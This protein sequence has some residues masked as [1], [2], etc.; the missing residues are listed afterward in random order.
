MQAA[1]INLIL[2]PGMDGTGDLF[3]PFIAALNEKTSSVKINIIT[4]SYPLNE[5]LSYPQLIKLASTH[6]PLDQPYI[7][8]GESF[9]GPV[10]IALASQGGNQLKG[11]ILCCTFARNPR[12]QLSRVSFML[13]TLPMNA[14]TMPIANRFLMANF[15]N[16]GVKKMLFSAQQKVSPRVM[17]AR[18]GAVIG[19]DYTEKLNSVK[20][21][22][23]YLQAINDYLVPP[24]A[25]KYIV[26]QAN[27][28][29]LVEL[30]APHML[31]QIAPSE[32]AE[33]V[34]TFMA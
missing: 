26:A 25:A 18:L 29:K 1:Q 2:L 7:L 23:L 27:N 28:V 4:V 22:I 6:I 19:V 34:K 14:L 31:L 32:A 10:A 3:A 33:C 30:N 21:P 8:L 17:R 5:V 11:L 9:S 15:M 20:V 24:S 16:D 13:P 12:P